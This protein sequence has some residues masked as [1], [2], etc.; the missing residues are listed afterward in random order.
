MSWIRCGRV[1]LYLT[2]DKFTRLYQIVKNNRK[3]WLNS[4]P[5]FIFPIVWGL[6]L[7]SIPS[8]FYHILRENVTLIGVETNLEPRENKNKVEILLQKCSMRFKITTP[9]RYTDHLSVLVD[10]VP[11]VIFVSWITSSYENW[12]VEFNSATPTING[13]EKI[14]QNN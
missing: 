6:T 5:S 1:S 3:K 4:I 12:R 2:H 11:A 10:I 14:Q 9:M 8:S 7:N 13:R